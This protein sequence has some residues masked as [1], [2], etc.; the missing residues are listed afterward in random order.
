MNK[1]RRIGVISTRLAGTDGVSLEAT[2]WISVLN[3]LGHECFYFA[4]ECEWPEDHTY[5]ISEAHF[6]HPDIDGLNIDLFDDYRRFR[7]TSSKVNQL[8]EHI[9]THLHKFV[10]KFR[11]DILIAE[12][13]LSIPMNI[14]LGLAFTE[15]IVETDLPT[16]AHHHDFSWERTRYAIS[17]AEDYLRAAFPPT[18]R[19]IH[20]VVINSFAQKELALRT[21]LSSTLIPNVMDFDTPP[22][23]LDDYTLGMRQELGIDEDE[24]ILLQPT[25]IVP[26]KRIE[27]SLELARRINMNCVVIISHHSGDEGKAYEAYLRDYAQLLGVKVIFGADRFNFNRGMTE[28]GKKIYS[29]VD[30]YLRADLVTYPSRVE[31]FGNAF[32]ETVYY[33]RPIVMST[34]EI[35]KTDIQPKGF[36]IIG[37]GDFIDTM[38]IDASRQILM[39]PS[40]AMEMTNTNYDIAHHHY[41]FDNL[42]YLLNSLLNDC[43]GNDL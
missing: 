41:S 29:L 25:R 26:R 24:F 8:K 13:I 33:R 22:P 17:G 38:C 5:L 32:L 37:F 1:G 6:A 2:K 43:V 42:K 11:P 9:K 39:N 28:D 7:D 16:I 4:G 27:L 34:Y 20:H 15:L 12:N 23:E 40:L 19:Q 35:F 31:G 3:S 21:G 36:R 18:L 30:A 10:T 14:P